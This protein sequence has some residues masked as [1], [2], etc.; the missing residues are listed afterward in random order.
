[1][2]HYQVNQG[3]TPMGIAKAFSGDMGRVGELVRANPHKQAI[4]RD[5]FVTFANLRRGEK[6]NIPWQQRGGMLHGAPGR[7]GAPPP[8]AL[9]PGAV[10]VD[11]NYAASSCGSWST[12]SSWPA[13]MT[14]QAVNINNS[15]PPDGAETFVW[16]ENRLWKFT[17]SGGNTV[18]ATCGSLAANFNPNSSATGSAGGGGGAGGAGGA[19]GGGGI[20]PVGLTTGGGSGSGTSWTP[21]L[22]GAGG[23]ILGLG[24]AYML[25]QRQQAHRPH[26]L[27][28]R[29]R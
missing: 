9:V 21:I 29:R 22:V 23:L 20:N 6:I 11:P 19:G 10:L 1:M 12:P 24:A 27:L 3:D 4:V 26:P 18:L 5:G 2:Q 25:S 17:S 14:T 8:F 7:L 15:G 13:D 16:Y 28:G